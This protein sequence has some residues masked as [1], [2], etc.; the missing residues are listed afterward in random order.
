MGRSCHGASDASCEEPVSLHLD[1]QKASVRGQPASW[2]PRGLGPGD[3]WS[4]CTFVV[5]PARTRYRQMARGPTPPRREGGTGSLEKR[6]PTPKAA[7]PRQFTCEKALEQGHPA[8]SFPGHVL[9]GGHLATFF[10]FS[11]D[12]V[13]EQTERGETC[14]LHCP[15][16]YPQGCCGRWTPGTRGVMRILGL[17]DTQRSMDLRDLAGVPAPRFLR[18]RH[19]SS[20]C[21]WLFILRKKTKETAYCRRRKRICLG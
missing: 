7:L 19:C 5:C 12:T 11:G 18:H 21:T 8:R 15:S 10:P 9:Q 1:A 2:E 4:P 16:A 6:P 3:G 20:P 13:W 14:S 17:R